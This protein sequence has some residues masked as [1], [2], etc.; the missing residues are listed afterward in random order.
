VFCY[1]NDNG[2]PLKYLNENGAAGNLTNNGATYSEINKSYIFDGVNDELNGLV[3]NFG[4]LSYH[5]SATFI[6]YNNINL[7]SDSQTIF[8]KDSDIG[9]RL[10]N[11]SNIIYCF[12]YNSTGSAINTPSIPV[13]LTNTLYTVDCDY[14]SDINILSIYVNGVYRTNI[15]TNKQSISSIYRIG[16]RASRYFNG[17]IN[18]VSIIN[19]SLS[20]AEVYQNYITQSITNRTGVVLEATFEN[21][22]I[23]TGT[24]SYSSKFSQ[25]FGY[26]CLGT[27]CFMNDASVSV[28]LPFKNSTSNST[29]TK[30][31]SLTNRN[32]TVVGVILNT[33]DESYI[34]DGTHKYINSNY[35][36]LGN[37]TNFTISIWVKRAV[38]GQRQHF[39]RSQS[40][41]VFVLD[42]GTN[43]VMTT[44][45]YYNA[46][47]VQSA[48]PPSI[49]DLNWHHVTLSTYYNITNNQTYVFNSM[50][51][52]VNGPATFNGMRYNLST[53]ICFGSAC[54]NFY[55]MNGSLDDARVFNRALSASEILAIYNEG[56]N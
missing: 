50:D 12:I 25:Y 52:V 45:I 10:N 26:G 29:Y 48:T 35:M 6:N 43:N 55:P 33:T 24:P 41:T 13:A 27:F 38:L 5:L 34:F 39:S 40:N 15:S 54:A 17:S 20:A 51:G 30:D 44:N 47:G 11:N 9:L 31:Y 23:V 14:N 7:S 46:T 49:T 21:N 1:T 53:N 32:I 8:W 42:V 36:L 3:T 28:N 37:Q 2:N 16:S 4:N 56:R 22:S 19:R 18:E